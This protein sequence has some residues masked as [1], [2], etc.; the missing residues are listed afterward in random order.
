MG[1]YDPGDARDSVPAPSPAATPSLMRPALFQLGQIN[2]TPGA[3]ETMNRKGIKLASLLLRHVSGDWGDLS[4]A[5]TQRNYQALQQGERVVSAYGTGPD[6]IYLI[7]ERNR[8][9]TTIIFA[10]EILDGN[11][12]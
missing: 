8:A 4:A 12:S 3:I 5:D 2:M 6:R 7:T 11:P 10:S 1:V 9:L